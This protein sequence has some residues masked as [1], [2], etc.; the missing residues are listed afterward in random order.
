MKWYA[1]HFIKQGCH[2]NLEFILEFSFMIGIYYT[3]SYNYRKLKLKFYWDA[4]SYWTF[5][6]HF[7][8]LGGGGEIWTFV[9]SSYQRPRT[10]ILQIEDLA[11][12]FMLY[13]IYETSYTSARLYLLYNSR[14]IIMLKTQQLCVFRDSIRR[15]HFLFS[16]CQ[17]MTSLHLWRQKMLNFV[18]ET[19]Y[20]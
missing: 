6:I 5:C 15:E 9:L 18:I 11:L 3:C 2:H 7:T 12:V 1:I 8:S 19:S 13:W 17:N 4:Q 14:Y 20:M 10:I 16:F